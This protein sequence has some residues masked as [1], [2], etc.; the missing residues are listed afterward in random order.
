M[1]GA[2][3]EGILAIVAG[4]LIVVVDTVVVV[5]VVLVGVDILAFT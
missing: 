5:V 3:A 2:S 1:A 4:E